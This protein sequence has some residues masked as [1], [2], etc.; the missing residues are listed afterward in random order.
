[1]S[2]REWELGK[3]VWALF[4]KWN[5]KFGLC[6][7][8][9]PC[10]CC[11]AHLW[12]RGWEGH[13]TRSWLWQRQP[14]CVGSQG[15][16]VASF[17]RIRQLNCQIWILS[18]FSCFFFLVSVHYFALHFCIFSDFL[19]LKFWF[20]QVMLLI[21]QTFT[22]EVAYINVHL[23]PLRNDVQSIHE[24]TYTNKMNKINRTKQK[25][26]RLIPPLRPVPPLLSLL[27]LDVGAI[28]AE[29]A[30]PSPRQL[31]CFLGCRDNYRQVHG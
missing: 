30:L 20:P 15:S 1:M 5:Q 2:E 13:G 3:G 16:T 27:L 6:L 12:W 24:N 18:F 26:Q 23:F 25:P 14:A 11:L 8:G 7:R 21:L 28:R 4:H 22:A 10:L 31:H 17:R 9:A 29:Q 19:L